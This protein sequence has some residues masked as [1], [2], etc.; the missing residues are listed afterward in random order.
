MSQMLP[1]VFG[2]LGEAIAQGMEGAGESAARF[3]ESTADNA[4]TAVRL[5]SDA[6]K[7]V[8]GRAAAIGD[9]AGRD[10][11]DGPITGDSG[12]PAIEESLA[13]DARAAP[14]DL[15]PGG[16]YDAV[17]LENGTPE[18]F[19]KVFPELMDTNAPRR[20]DPEAPGNFRQNCMS[21]TVATERTLAGSDASAVPKP[22]GGFTWKSFGKAA[23]LRRFK[24]KNFRTL[25]SDD[26]VREMA[27][28]GDGARGIVWGRRFRMVDGV[29]KETTGHIFNITTRYGRVFYV[30]GQKA[31]FGSP[32]GS[33]DTGPYDSISFLR[34]K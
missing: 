4:D 10:A 22:E 33:P 30:D 25:S 14:V 32:L 16:K 8:A 9:S 11:S 13:G 31:Q 19:G 34:T 3:F 12:A 1:E 2:E 17:T 21:C 7:Q 24:A 28:A 27:D 5:V 29:Q 23:G 26:I 20:A 18:Q 15:P 6:D